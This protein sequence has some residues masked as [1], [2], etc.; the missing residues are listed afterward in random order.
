MASILLERWPPIPSGLWQV[1][2]AEASP[3]VPVY[4]SGSGVGVAMNAQAS[5][6]SDPASLPFIEQSFT[7]PLDLRRTGGSTTDAP[8]FFQELRFWL[9]S[10]RVGSGQTPRQGYYLLFEIANDD[11][12]LSQEWFIPVKQA[13]TWELHRLWLGD[14]PEPLLQAI[15][16]LRFRA[17]DNAQSF[18]AVLGDVIVTTPEPIQDA[19]TELLNRLDG[20][21]EV[22]IQNSLNPV[23]AFVELPENPGGRTPPYILITPWS[24]Q[25]QRE[26]GGSGD[27]ADN[28]RRTLRTLPTGE[29]LEVI[30]AAQRPAMKQVALEYAIDVFAEDRLQKTQLLDS[31]LADFSRQ[32][33]LVVNLEPLTLSSFNPTPERATE[34]A[35]PGRTPLYLQVTVDIEAGDRQFTTIAERPQLQFNPLDKGGQPV[36]TEPETALI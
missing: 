26:R 2:P 23:P 20:T 22:V 21:F 15:T 5:E 4:I 14:L 35:I 12:E 6:S 8:A 19:D 28:Y 7:P 11:L 25:L 33:Y 32:L 13:N 1:L 9:R 18:Q 3:M 34:F 31:V 27:I 36:V 10:S 30:Q 24:V 17:L 29:T 16:T